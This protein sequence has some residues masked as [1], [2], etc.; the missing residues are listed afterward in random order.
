[1]IAIL[2]QHA[3]SV[4]S[5][6]GSWHLR[7]APAVFVIL[8]L[9]AFAPAFAAARRSDP[10]A[11]PWTRAAVYAVG[12]ALMAAPLCSPLNTAA[13]RYLLSAHMLEHVLVADAGPVLLVL[14]VRGPIARA[15]SARLRLLRP[16]TDVLLRPGVTLAAWVGVIGLWHVPSL[17]DRA[18]GS[19]ALHNLEHASFVL[20]GT[21]VWIQMIDPAERGRLGLPGRLAFTVA[22]FFAGQV[23]SDA[24]VFSFHAYYPAYADRPGR[25]LGL[26]PLADQRLAGIVMALEQLLTLGTCFALLL[27]ALRRDGRLQRAVIRA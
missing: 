8:A 6:A 9:A 25:L 2:A 5:V 12:L 15:M 27:L 19:A 14:A 3:V 24:L 17:Y 21:L 11:A 16:V 13:E 7:A 18:L 26:T 22:V 23:L 4:S 10:A 20:V 1:M